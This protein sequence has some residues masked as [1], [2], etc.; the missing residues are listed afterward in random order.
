M[1]TKLIRRI[2]GHGDAPTAR[3]AA[4]HTGSHKPHRS[5][6]HTS[7]HSAHVV[8][9]NVHQIDPALIS[10][11]AVKVT[12]TLQQAGYQAFI[13]G[14]AVR[15]LLLG[16]QPKDFDVATN[17]TPDQ[18]STLFRRSRIIGRRFQIVHVTFYGGR[19]QEI[20]EVSTFRALVDAQDSTQIS[21]RRSGAKLKRGELDRHTHATDSSGRVLRDNVW[22]SQEED[23]TRRD[24]TINAMYYDPAT[25][26]VHDYH[27]GMTDIQARTLRM[28]GDPATR[29]RED[30]IRMLRAVR[31]AAKTGFQIEPATLAPIR[32]LAPLLHNVPTARL[33]DEMLKLL[34]SGHAWASLQTL[35]SAGLQQ[36]LLPLLDVI[37]EQP[38]GERFVQLALASTDA[39]VQAGKPVSPG[40]LFSTMLWHQVLQ[41]WQTYRQAGDLPIPALHT[42]MDAVLDSQMEKLAIQRRHVGDMK[43]IWSMQPRFEKRSGRLPFRLLENPR[44]RA[45]YDFLLL[46]CESG[47]LPLELG[48]WWT[49][50]QHAESDVREHMIQTAAQA[51]RQTGTQQAA[52]GTGRK[53]RRGGRN[54]QRSGDK[55]ATVTETSDTPSAQRDESKGS[56]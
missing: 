56:A 40:F 10:R 18:V 37:L 9:A 28:I 35:R 42:A 53:R 54:R 38:L 46:R 48:Q 24:F 20:I 50:F 43:D 27:S 30:P 3:H 16:I 34:M 22:G 15:D 36:G 26:T 21:E 41:H 1:I 17:A 13:V 25:E 39:R 19:E 5:H 4:P 52:E 51:A 2:F 49:D 33:F 8:A 55:S 12:T 7:A 11:N 23:A 47:E 14:G 31:F 45:G 6:G 29:Y 32:E 44:F